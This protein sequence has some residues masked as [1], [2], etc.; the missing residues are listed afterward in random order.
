MISFPSAGY[1]NSTYS[2]IFCLATDN[3]GTQ[4]VTLLFLYEWK[5]GE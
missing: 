5:H 3:S 1:K 4:C 2:L